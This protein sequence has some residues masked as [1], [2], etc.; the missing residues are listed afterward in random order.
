MGGQKP[1][2]IDYCGAKL[3]LFCSVLAGV[4][5]TV[6][7]SR[8]QLWIHL[9]GTLKWC[10]VLMLFSA[11]AVDGCRDLEVAADLSSPAPSLLGWD[12]EPVK[13]RAPPKATVGGEQ[14]C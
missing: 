3:M 5:C 14:L 13:G 4:D 1:V 6:S 9:L 8:G 11:S 12:G 2:L 10:S 7:V